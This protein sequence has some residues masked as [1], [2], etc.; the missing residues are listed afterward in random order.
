MDLLNTEEIN[1]DLFDVNDVRVLLVDDSKTARKHIKRVLQGMGLI[2]IIEAENGAN[3]LSALKQH[4][5]DLVV[6]D[7]NM[8]EMDGRESCQNSSDLI[9]QRRTFQLL[10]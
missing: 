6:T 1:L 2:N 4:Q 7:F 8:P 9:P 10:W 5:F 3:A